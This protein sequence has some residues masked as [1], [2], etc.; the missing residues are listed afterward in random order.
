[1]TR[2]P[3]RPPQ[4]YLLVEG[5]LTI[6]RLKPTGPPSAHTLV[7]TPTT[8][9]SAHARDA[10]LEAATIQPGEETTRGAVIWFGFKV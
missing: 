1:M 7:Q 3:P 5:T 10:P 6:E 8:Y 9:Y 2:R 4:L